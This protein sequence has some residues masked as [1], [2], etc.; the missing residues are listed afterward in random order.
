[1]TKKIKSPADNGYG[2]KRNPFLSPEEYWEYCNSFKPP[3]Y[4]EEARK[5]RR[6]ELKKKD[7]PHPNILKSARSHVV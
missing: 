2:T 5:R 6:E 3:I 4:G 1:M 7:L